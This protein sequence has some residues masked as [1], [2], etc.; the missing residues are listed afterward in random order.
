MLNKL[1]VKKYTDVDKEEWDSFVLNDSVNGTFLQT[2]NFLNYHPSDRFKDESIMVYDDNR[3]VAV[4]PGCRL[5]D[6]GKE[7]FFSHKGTSYGGILIKRKF[8]NVERTMEIISCIDEYLL[9]RFERVIFKITPDLFCKE[10]SDLLQYGLKHYGYTNYDELS[11]YVDLSE[12]PLNVEDKF[13]RNKKRNIKKCIDRGL[14]FRELETKEEISEFHRLLTINLQK[15]NH[16]PIH[17]LPDLYDLKFNREYDNIQF[18]GAF[19]QNEIVAAGMMFCFDGTVFHAQN[20]SYDYH[21][22][23]YSPISYLYYKVIEYG[24]KQGYSYLSWGI[25]TEDCGKVIN[26]GLIRNKESYGSKYQV[27]RTFVKN[28]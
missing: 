14:T 22:E 13:D 15:Y 21:M 16:T 8:Y 10:N 28:F 27:N 12:F 18:F 6:D 26:Y 19:E 17:S 9:S 23:D 3:L 5:I 11:S 20:L 25:S 1:N 2:M 24:K 7:C 4:A